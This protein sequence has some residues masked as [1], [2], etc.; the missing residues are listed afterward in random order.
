MKKR[1]AQLKSWDTLMILL[2]ISQCIYYGYQNIIPLE[3]QSLHIWRQSDCASYTWGYATQ[4]LNFFQPEMNNLAP[5]GTGQV[6]T[7][8]PILYYISGVLY[9]VFGIVPAIPRIL[10]ISFMLIGLFSLYRILKELFTQKFWPIIIPMFLFTSPLL[11]FFTNNFLPD[12]PAFGLSIWATYYFFL[13]ATKGHTRKHYILSLSLFLLA[14]LLK[15][16][17]VLPFLVLLCIY[18]IE[19][20]PALR[21]N[22]LRLPTELFALTNKQHILSFFG[23]FLLF[24]SWYIYASWYSTRT[25]ID[26][27]ASI[28]SPAYGMSFQEIL[29]QINDI[30]NNLNLEFYY[31][32]STQIFL[33]VLS[34]GLLLGLGKPSFINRLIFLLLLLG[35]L[36]YL[37]FFLEILSLHEYYF[38]PLYLCGIPVLLYG[39]RLFDRYIPTGRPRQIGQVL[40]ILFLIINI[41]H[42]KSQMQIRYYGRGM[43]YRENLTFYTDE[44]REF[45]LE[46]GVTMESRVISYPDPSMNNTLYLMRRKGWSSL[47]IERMDADFV[48]QLKYE[49]AEYLILSDTTYRQDSLLKPALINQ[50]GSMGG[51]DIYDLTELKR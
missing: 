31:L 51:I 40:I 42:A 32:E 6:A 33:G 21:K 39:A 11:A 3:P 46:K 13:Y 34:L 4:T 50:I 20:I 22:L 5:N 16:S 36:A 48:T 47:G 7:E 28:T 45:L 15:L 49:G 14:A 23:V 25:A 37:S 9:R 24:S 29:T 12:M 2:L 44:F 1:L 41:Y 8:F 35:G 26:H 17:F 19:Q 10:N 38:A 30:A 18:L 27:F 43:N